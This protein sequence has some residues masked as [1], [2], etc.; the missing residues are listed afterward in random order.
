MQFTHMI[1]EIH[2][3]YR[4]YTQYTHMTQ[5]VHAVHTHD[6]E[7]TCSSHTW[8]RKYTYHTH[9]TGSICSS[10]TWHKKYTHHTHDTGSTCSSHTWHRKNMQFTYMTHEVHAVHT[11]H[12]YDIYRFTNTGSVLCIFNFNS[13]RRQASHKREH[14]D[15]TSQRPVNTRFP[16]TPPAPGTPGFRRRWMC[17]RCSQCPPY[18]DQS[19]LSSGTLQRPATDCPVSGPCKPKAATIIIIACIL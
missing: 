9:D 5:K 1:Q 10:H 4:K 3:L 19:R 18:T 11:H 14:P 13:P 7:S 12:T 2:T 16:S 17:G 8:H 6:T 15:P